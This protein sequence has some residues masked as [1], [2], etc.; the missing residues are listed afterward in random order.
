MVKVSTL[1]VVFLCVFAVTVNAQNITGSMSGRVID[2]QGASVPGAKVTLTAPSKNLTLTTKTDESGDFLFPGLQPGE[3]SL[4]IEAT[5]F[6]K[7]QNRSI[8]LDA[9]DRLALGNITLDVGSLTE[10]VEISA[11]VALLSTES[12]ERGGVLVA[13]QIENIMVNGRNPLAMIGLVPGVVSTANFQVGGAGGIG[14][15]FVDGNRGSANMLSINGID[16][17]DT[18]SNGSQ[19]VTVSIDSTE[20]FKILTGQYQAEYGRNAGAQISVV[21]KS[22][23]SQF[24]GSGYLYHRHEEFNANTWLNNAKSLPRQLY[25]YNDPGYT[26]GGPVFIPK[27]LPKNRVFFFWSQEWQLQLV[28]NTARNVM[29]PTALERTGDFSQSVD[30]NNKPLAAIIDPSNGKPFGGKIIPPQQL[31]GP[32]VA[33]L[34]LFPLPNVTGQVG[35]NYTS[36]ISGH[37][38]RREDLLRVDYNITSN[39]RAFGH[40]I[41]NAQPLVMPY[42]SFVLGINVPVVPINYPNPGKSW[43]G[44][45]TWVLG[46][47]TTNEFNMG[48]THNSIDIIEGGTALTRTTS[49]INFPMLYPN[50][51]QDDYIPGVNFGGTHLANSP[52]FNSVGDAPFHNYN[53]VINFSDNLTKVWGAHRIKIGAFLERSRK[54]QSSF[55]NNNGFFNFGDSTSNPIDTG[56]GYSNAILGV[57]QTFDQASAYINGQY[58]YWNIE[59]FIQDTWKVTSRLTLDYGLRIAWYQPQY[60]ASFQAS[61]FVLADWSASKAPRLYTPKIVNGVRSAYDAV[62][63]Q[64]LP[65]YLCL[66]VHGIGIPEERRVVVE[67]RVLRDARSSSRRPAAGRARFPSSRGTAPARALRCPRARR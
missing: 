21:T 5:G 22:G 40:Y 20:E 42:G 54:D 48:Y 11:D 9:N 23:S 45:V 27:L 61:T 47:T 12:A 63:N 52:A 59:P 44:G 30:N 31:Y 50:A 67:H 66:G 41:N 36:Q 24:H 35:Y 6:K 34:K 49:G 25:R 18:G 37:S 19:N 39:I 64:V 65:G 28:P 13:R 10:S 3:Y 1:I 14:S 33:L 17:L 38:P 53:T 57:Y 46:P 2:P 58:R 60:D 29:L 16:N 7:V 32:G 15:I 26:V 55:G 51:V 8:P 43:A 62:T 4:S 56:Y